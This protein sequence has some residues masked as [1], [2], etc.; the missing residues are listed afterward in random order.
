MNVSINQILG[1]DVDEGTEEGDQGGE[2]R[3]SPNR[4]P[5]DEIIGEEGC[6]KGLISLEHLLQ[7]RVADKLGRIP[8]QGTTVTF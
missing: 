1:L 6:E 8:M 4:E 3:Q 5:F 2:E 7:K